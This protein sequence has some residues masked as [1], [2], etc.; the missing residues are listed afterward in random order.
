MIQF[1][2]QGGHGSHGPRAQ[3]LSGVTPGSRCGDIATTQASAIVGLD[4]LAFWGH[5]DAHK[6]CNKSPDQL[7]SL[8]KDWKRL[9]PALK[10]IE[11]IT[12]NARHAVGTNPFANRLKSKFG[13]LS[14]TRGMVVKALPVTV[15]G[16]NNAWSI[17][18]AET[19][20]NSWCYVTAPGTDDKLLMQAQSLIAFEQNETG[21]LR[22]YRGDI[23]TRADQMVRANPQ[24]QWTMNYG[25]FNTL[26]AHLGVVR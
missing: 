22:S 13:V 24:R 23:A 17:L 10:T 14:G 3:A 12:C 9:N 26:R 5:G 11:I 2:F 8:I 7:F 15:T 21:G 25:Y 1:L 20:H 6:L 19:I 4:T 18:L 16:K